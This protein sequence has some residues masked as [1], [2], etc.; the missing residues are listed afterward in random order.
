MKLPSLFN[1][2]NDMALA[3][4]VRQYFPPRR[5]QQMED[6]LK[7]LALLWDD[8]PW[9]W[10]LAI[11]QRYLGMGVPESKLPSD[12]WLAEVRRLSSRQFGVSYYKKL[13][14]AYKPHRPNKS[15]ETNGLVSCEACF[16]TSLQQL[17]FFTLHSSLLILKSPWSS[18]GRGNMV[19]D[20]IVENFDNLAK[21]RIERTI[22]E[23]GGVVVEPFYANKAL[24]FAMEFNVTD[25][26]AKFLGYSVFSADETGRYKGNVVAS[27]EELLRLIGLPHTLLDSLIDY[28]QRELA[29]LAYRGPVG[30]DMMRLADGCVHP[31][32]EVN[33]RRTMGWLAIQI[34]DRF[35][36]ADLLL[37]GNREHGF[38]AFVESNKLIISFNQ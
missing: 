17:Q 15:Y 18:S 5:I 35:G 8:G 2:W 33:F 13:D 12:E 6:D 29:K 38:S 3:L 30:I 11:K 25:D 23:Q 28:H 14:E 31:C 24:D 26:G 32:V 36:S 34:Y 20:K 21:Q 16:V 22:R 9:G 10:S 19:F 27:Q 7:D 4:N 37:A 1:P